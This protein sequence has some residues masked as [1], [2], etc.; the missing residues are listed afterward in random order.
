MSNFK[1]TWRIGP[2]VYGEKAKWE[3]F[4]RLIDK[5]DDVADEVA[6]Y[7]AD[8]NY[9]ELSPLDDKRKQAE[10]CKECFKQLRERG[11]TVG[12]NVWP[13]FTLYSLEQNVYPNIPRMI[14][15]DGNVVKN[16]ACPLSEEFTEYMSEKFKIFAD[17][18]PDFIW[19]DDDC[20]FTHLG[21]KYPCF[22]ENCVKGFKDGAYKS[23][24]ELVEALNNKENRDLRIAWSSYGAERLASF[25]KKM[26]NTVDEIDPDIDMPLMTIGATHTT[27]SGDYIEQCM[28]AL[29]SRR[30]RPGHDLYNDKSLDKIMWKALEVGRQIS[31]Y[32]EAVKDILWEEDSFPQ[33]HLAKS[34][35]TRQNEVSLGLMA[36][37][38]GIAFN[39]LGLNGTLDLRFGREVDELHTLRPRWEKFLDFAKDL[40]P[41]G[42]WPIYSWFLT[43]KGKMEYVWLK[44]RTN[45]EGQNPYADITLP[46]KIGPFGIP[47]VSDSYN[48]CA[49]LISGKTITAFNTDEI[50]KIFSGNVYMDG[51]ALA[52]LEEMGLAELAG[53]KADPVDYPAKVC[54]LT[55]HPFN[56]SFAEY[57]YRVLPRKGYTLLPLND[58]VEW[59]GYRKNIFGEGDKWYISKYENSLGG[60]VIVNGFDAWQQC[61]TP[62]NLYQFASIAEWFDSPLRLKY[63]NAEAVSRVQPYIRT[64]GKKAAI[65]LFNASLDTTNPFEV[66]VKGDM[67]KAILLK[68]DGSEIPLTCHR[69]K[70]HLYVNVPTISPYDI[71]FI[72]AK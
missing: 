29:R 46:E 21:G 9:P 1:L 65:Q 62:S 8:D 60:K 57:N 24:E 28:K 33:G 15:M 14:D 47:L 6:F 53:V 34:F 39:H 20:R 45:P 52:A 7:I 61:D 63:E 36:G 54:H 48:S 38:T 3:S 55:D 11:I 43:A 30:G 35:K 71:T 51:S 12:I 68:A 72:L 42:M 56:G 13:T 67:T 4:L 10:I 40:K 2:K 44:E 64:D 70:E 27:F 50:K 49:T 5:Y 23:R 66:I 26:R 16:H 31:L 19:I 18:N 17:T 32:P 69:G 41:A 58:K 37:C 59:L 22:C 25:C